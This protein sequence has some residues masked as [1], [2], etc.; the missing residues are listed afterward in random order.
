MLGR[1]VVKRTISA[2]SQVFESWYS[3]E[4]G[5]VPLRERVT[6]VDSAGAARVVSAELQFGEP[7]EKLFA[8]PAWPERSPSAVVALMERKFGLST[9]LSEGPGAKQKD[10]AYWSQQARRP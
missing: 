9:G 5:C 1:R 10:R 8:V 4:L 6:R 3:P 7:D 2:A